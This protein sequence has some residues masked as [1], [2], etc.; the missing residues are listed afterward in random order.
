MEVLN[1][2]SASLTNY[3][4]L[5]HLQKIK[6]AKKKHKGQLATITYETLHYLEETPCK[7][8]TPTNLSECIRE[9]EPF[10]LNKNELVMIMNTPPTTPLEIQL[11]IEESEERLTEEQVQELL[12]ILER[13]FP[14]VEPKN[15]VEGEVDANSS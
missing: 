13:Y 8:Q 1:S 7:S 11:M 15:T 12:T 14:K 2:N 3:E 5:K 10:N 6:D 9:L 4:V